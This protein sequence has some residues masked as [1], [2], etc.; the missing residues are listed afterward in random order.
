[1][2]VPSIDSAGMKVMN[3]VAIDAICTLL[4]AAIETNEGGMP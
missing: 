2:A 4:T 3:G 1:M